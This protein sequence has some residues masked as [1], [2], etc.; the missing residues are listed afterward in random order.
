MFTRK[1]LSSRVMVMEGF[2]CL[3]PFA[4]WKSV[5]VDVLLG[6]MLPQSGVVVLGEA[7]GTFKQSTCDE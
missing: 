7:G 3:R 4:G 2:S 5:V 6:R 1:K